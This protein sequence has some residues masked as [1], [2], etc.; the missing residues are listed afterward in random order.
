MWKKAKDQTEKIQNKYVV[1]KIDC[2]NCDKTYVGQKKRLLETKVNEKQK[3]QN[4]N[5]KYHN[6]ISK[7]IEENN[8]HN[9]DWENVNILHKE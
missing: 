8:G 7:H 4:Y 6:I 1:Y 5:E 2:K 3:N 9:I